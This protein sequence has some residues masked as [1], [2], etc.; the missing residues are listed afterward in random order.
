MLKKMI[1]K[2]IVPCNC[3]VKNQGKD[4]PTMRGS[5][6]IYKELLKRPLKQTIGFSVTEQKS[7]LSKTFHLTWLS[8]L[9]TFL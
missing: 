1:S 6:F 7:S 9:V 8:P 3:L 4:N 2:T 5:T